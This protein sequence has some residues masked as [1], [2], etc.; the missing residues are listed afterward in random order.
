MHRI[1]I[2]VTC[3]SSCYTFVILQTFK[4]NYN[5]WG[6]FIDAWFDLLAL[7]LTKTHASMP[8]K[9]NASLM[10]FVFKHT[11]R[12][13][14]CATNVSFLWHCEWYWGN[15]REHIQHWD[16]ESSS[17]SIIWSPM[18]QVSSRWKYSEKVHITKYFLFL[19]Y[20]NVLIVWWFF[21]KK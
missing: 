12:Y 9:L 4:K 3:T 15:I 10:P 20:F 18:M 16:M 14:D 1:P 7:S 21:L 5:M 6:Q 2:V 17:S 19:F 13:L 11:S 8:R